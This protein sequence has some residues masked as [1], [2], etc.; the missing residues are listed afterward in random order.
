MRIEQGTDKPFKQF[1][2]DLKLLYKE[3]GYNYTMVD[4]KLRDRIAFRIKSKS[5][6][7]LSMEAMNW[8]LKI[9]DISRTYELGIY[10]TLV[11]IYIFVPSEINFW[12]HSKERKR[13]ASLI[14]IP[15]KNKQ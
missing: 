11:K 13:K 6:E 8:H 12:Q 2:S 4:G 1:V 9:Y 15:M 5:E 7:N 3:W 10:E 14:N